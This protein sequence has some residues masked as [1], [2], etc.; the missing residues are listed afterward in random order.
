VEQLT[1]TDM[2]KYLKLLV[3]IVTVIFAP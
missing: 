3:H 1:Y 2:P